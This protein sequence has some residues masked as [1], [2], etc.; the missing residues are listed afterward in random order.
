LKFS[1]IF[2]T[3]SRVKFDELLYIIIEVWT[4]GMFSVYII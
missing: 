4:Q 3:F 1:N 2:F